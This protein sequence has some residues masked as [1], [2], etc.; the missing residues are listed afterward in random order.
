MFKWIMLVVLAR[1]E[2]NDESA[3]SDPAARKVEKKKKKKKAHWKL[4]VSQQAHRVSTY[5]K[6]SE[7]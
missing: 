7:A 6:I 5:L 2:A 4:Q 1:V 3:R